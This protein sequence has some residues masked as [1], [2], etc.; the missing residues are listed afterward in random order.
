MAGIAGM[1]F[2][3]ADIILIFLNFFLS[4]PV[5]IAIISLYVYQLS[6]VVENQTSVED[7]ICR[8]ARK[9]A[10]RQGIVRC[11]TEPSYK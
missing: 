7:Y 11:S 10:R 8:R 6:C 3:V 2:E 5:T 1:G 9:I 4:L